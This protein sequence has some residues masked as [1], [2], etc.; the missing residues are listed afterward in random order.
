[1]KRIIKCITVIAVSICMIFSTNINIRA[2]N[3]NLAL[4]G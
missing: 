2:A 3:T 4:S 1:M